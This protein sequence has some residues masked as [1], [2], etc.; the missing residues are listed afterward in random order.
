MSTLMF[1]LSAVTAGGSTVFPRLGVGAQPSAG[2]AVFWHNIQ[3]D[4]WSDMAML[5]GGCPVILGR[6]VV[7][8]KWIREVANMER[9]RCG[10][11]PDIHQYTMY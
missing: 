6:K 3:R 8:N 4:G 2:S 10:A 1:Y 11:Q 7:A 9:R 5:H